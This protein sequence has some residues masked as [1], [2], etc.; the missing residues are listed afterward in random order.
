MSQFQNKEDEGMVNRKR[1][2]RGRNN[3][4][5]DGRYDPSLSPL[6]P[7]MI[8]SRNPAKNYNKYYPIHIRS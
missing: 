3:G 4:E 2:A 8:N 7:P 6:P 1:D 5:G